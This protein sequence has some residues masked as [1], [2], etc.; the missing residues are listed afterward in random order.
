MGA[1]SIWHILIL[2]VVLAVFVAVLA[3][4][5]RLSHMASAAIGQGT[6]ER[7]VDVA[8]ATAAGVAAAFR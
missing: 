7:G 3:G 6:I 4:R 8:A 5:R 2:F 1:L